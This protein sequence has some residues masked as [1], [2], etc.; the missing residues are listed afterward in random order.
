MSDT[1]QKN[2][3]RFGIIAAF[4]LVATGLTSCEGGGKQSS[5]ITAA[6]VPSGSTTTDAENFAPA[7][8]TTEQAGTDNPKAPAANGIRP[9]R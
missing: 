2:G 4:L 1:Y 3:V 7:G 5:N 9:V 8:K 6:P